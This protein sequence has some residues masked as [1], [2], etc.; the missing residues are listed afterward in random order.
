MASNLSSGAVHKDVVIARELL[1]ETDV[2]GPLVNMTSRLLTEV[3]AELGEQAEYLEAIE[4]IDER[5]GVV[6]R[7]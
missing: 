4:W 5:A 6:I 2:P 3:R 1:Q 7:G